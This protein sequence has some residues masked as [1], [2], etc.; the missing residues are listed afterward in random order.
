ML[1]E[2]CFI[3]G[4]KLAGAVLASAWQ[5]TQPVFTLIISLCLGWEAFTLG[6]AAG[7]VISFGGAAFMVSYG[8]DFSSSSAG[9]TIAG[10][11]LLA[12]NCLGT[13]L[14]VICGKLVLGR[15]YS[16]FT[17]TAWSY[18][19]GAVMMLAVASGFS[20]SCDIVAFICPEDHKNPQANTRVDLHAIFM[21]LHAV[22]YLLLPSIVFCHLASPTV[23][24]RH[25]LSYRTTSSPATG[26]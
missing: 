2:A 24:F 13:S 21:R 7:V 20:S 18:L 1:A 26:T 25:M 16:A 6:K 15:G 11:A 14:Y 12:A 22:T 10:N 8:A 23:T 4:Y 17:V 3:I 5:P 9:Q 19:C